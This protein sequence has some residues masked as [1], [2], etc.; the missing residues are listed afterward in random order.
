MH[1]PQ[2]SLLNTRRFLPL[3]LTQ[4]WGAFN[5]NAFKSTMAVLITYVLI[6]DISHAQLLVNLGGGVFIL[7]FFLFSTLAGELS[8]KYDRAL[9]VRILKSLEILFMVLGM[10]GFYL[11]NVPIL[12]MTLFLMGVHSTFFGPIKY[13]A[14]PDLLRPQELLAGNGLV[15]GST[16]IAILVGTILGTQLG[17]TTTGAL[18]ASG[19]CIGVAV[20]GW[21]SSLFMPRVPLGDP[22]LKIHANIFTAI[23]RLLCF[24]RE[25]RPV[26]LS[27]L[28]MSWFWF[29]GFI[30]ITQF[31]IYTRAIIGG[32]EHVVTLFLVA[33]S[34]GIAIG[35]LL[36]NHFLHGKVHA[37]YVP[38]CMLL[39]TVFT[40]DLCWASHGQVPVLPYGGGV[41]AFLSRFS[42]W[43]ITLDLLLLSVAGGFYI[44]PLYALMQVKSEVAHRSRIVACNNIIGALFMFAAAVL[45]MALTAIGFNSTQLFLVMGVANA[46]VTFY[47][48]KKLLQIV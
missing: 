10:L 11:G 39:M 16:F 44:V 4:F 36:C 34:V 13:S 28:A 23:W 17:V 37:R 5:D 14:L 22:G 3:F 24:T 27:I 26:Y 21:I 40:L 25:N 35:S 20:L 6:T 1:S 30:F 48:W 12:M 46:L 31:P 2:F 33:F 45:A 42:G 47:A 7:P 29:M 41:A 19:I 32:D 18:L 15:E 38:I 9:L 8:D 43:R